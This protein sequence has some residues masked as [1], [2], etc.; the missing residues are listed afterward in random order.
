MRRHRKVQLWPQTLSPMSLNVKNYRIIE[1]ITQNKNVDL[2]CACVFTCIHCSSKN[3]VC[4]CEC[5][6]LFLF[7]L[8]SLSVGFSQSF[9]QSL[10]FLSRF[11]RLNSLIHRCK[12]QIN[13]SSRARMSFALRTF[14]H[15]VALFISRSTFLC[16]YS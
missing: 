5:G 8:M 16:S 6:M 3:G 13:V 11:Y 2:T 14:L 12:R 1:T 10:L 7:H 15:A 9:S 4:D